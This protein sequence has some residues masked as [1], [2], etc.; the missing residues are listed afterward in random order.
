[1]DGGVTNNFPVVPAKKAYPR[2]KII[3][4]SFNKYRTNPK[5]ENLFDSLMVAFDIM[6]KKD[7]PEQGSLSDVFFCRDLDTPILEFTMT[8]L[9]KI[10]KLG[11]EDGLE[12][13]R[14]LG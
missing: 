7:V 10:F 3:G 1:M 11:Y 13:L 9:K 12:K 6:I 5:V 4:I 14:A 2:H 8:K